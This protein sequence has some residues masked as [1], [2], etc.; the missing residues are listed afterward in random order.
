MDVRRCII[1]DEPITEENNSQAHVIPSALGGRLK[2]WD[3]LSK[4]GNG[5]LGDKIDL[6]LIQAFQALMTMLNATR[7]PG[8]A[9]L[10]RIR[11]TQCTE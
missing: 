3:I 8:K 2:P 10:Y 5:L 11:L 7:D 9:S 1:T 6:P 4:K